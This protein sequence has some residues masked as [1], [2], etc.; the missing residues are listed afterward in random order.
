M[1]ELGQASLPWFLMRRVWKLSISHVQH[2]TVCAPHR[3]G[4]ARRIGGGMRGPRPIK[5]KSRGLVTTAGDSKFE[6]AV[7]QVMKNVSSQRMRS[8]YSFS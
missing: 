5:F 4:Y 2:V 1:E 8:L 6:L 3:W 7:P